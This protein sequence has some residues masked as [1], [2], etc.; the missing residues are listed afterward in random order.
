MRPRRLACDAE[1]VEFEGYVMSEDGAYM[2]LMIM[3]LD[4][5]GDPERVEYINGNHLDNR[6]ENLR[7]REGK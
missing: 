7:L 1:D 4:P 5:Y 6:R 2:H 3:G